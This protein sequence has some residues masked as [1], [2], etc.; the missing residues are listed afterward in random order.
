MKVMSMRRITVLVTYYSRTGN[1]EMMAKAVAEGAS[2]VKDVEVVLKR[3]EDTSV[4]DLLKADAI[5]IGS[6]TYYGQLAWPVKKLIDESVKYHGRL[7]GK[8]GAAFTS[9]GGLGGGAE[10]TLLSIIKAMLIHGMIIQ[11]SAEEYHYGVVAIGE[12]DENALEACRELGRRVAELALK[13][14]A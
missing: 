11:G 14:K 6:P 1:T 5:I 8:V 3:V 7:E 9:C 12:P 4:E 2:K 13:L 10:T